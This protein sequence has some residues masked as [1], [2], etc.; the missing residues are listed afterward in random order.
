MSKRSM[1]RKRADEFSSLYLYLHLNFN[2]LKTACR[3]IYS[4]LIN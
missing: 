1:K 3:I 2:Q 4:K